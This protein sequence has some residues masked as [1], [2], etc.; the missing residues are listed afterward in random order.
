MPL[1]PQEALTEIHD[2][3]LET[4]AVNNVMNQLLL[5][6][7]D[8]R[9]WCAQL[10]GGKG[11]TIAAIFAYLHNIRCKW[12]RL[13]TPHLQPPPR[14]TARAARRSRPRKPWRRAAHSARSS[15]WPRQEVSSR[16]LGPAV[17]SGRVHVRLHVFARGSSPRANSNAGHT[18][19]AI[20]CRAQP[21]LASGNGK[22][23]GSKPA[24]RLARANNSQ[25]RKQSVTYRGPGAPRALPSLFSPG[26]FSSIPPSSR[27][28]AF[29]PCTRTRS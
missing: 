29:R 8:P 20:A 21:A 18:N 13:S 22:N 23:C 19:S 27:N 28:G 26:R 6:P 24:S 25:N 14:W 3:L 16:R 11:R 2:V 1:R 5:Y 15:R 9:V 12:L 10:P 7:L 4:F 17:A